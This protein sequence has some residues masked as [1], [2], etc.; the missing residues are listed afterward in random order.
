MLIVLLFGYLAR[1]G[2]LAPAQNALVKLKYYYK[3]KRVAF[4]RV[5]N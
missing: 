5:F 3:G 4:A 1:T 2:R